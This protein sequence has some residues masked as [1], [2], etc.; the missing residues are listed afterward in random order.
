MIK[1]YCDSCG[2]LIPFSV[3]KGLEG[4]VSIP[5]RNGTI[6][7]EVIQGWSESNKAVWN[8]GHICRDCLEL[9]IGLIIQTEAGHGKGK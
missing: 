2:E 5:G 9:A 8:A 3:C 6:S 4:S 7:I 1:Y